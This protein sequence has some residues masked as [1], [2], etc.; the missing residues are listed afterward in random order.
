MLLVVAWLFAGKTPAADSRFGEGQGVGAQVLPAR[1]RA[2]IGAAD[3][4]GLRSQWSHDFPL[5][6]AFEGFARNGNAF[7]EARW[8]K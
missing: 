4:V 3:A 2:M 7:H 5:L 8:R 6:A 1:L